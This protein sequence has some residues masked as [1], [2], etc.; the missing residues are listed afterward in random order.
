MLTRIH[1]VDAHAFASGDKHA[2]AQGKELGLLSDGKGF[3]VAGAR[4]SFY[5]KS[6]S[7]CLITGLDLALAVPEEFMVASKE[8]APRGQTHP[9]F[10]HTNQSGE[11][12]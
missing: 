11:L 12:C 4:T 10:V 6:G 1:T 3:A 8:K 5:S 9:L 2:F 7:P